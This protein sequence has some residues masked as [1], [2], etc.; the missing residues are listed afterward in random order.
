MGRPRAKERDGEQLVSGALRTYTACILCCP[1]W[2]Q[3]MVPQNNYNINV[4]DL[5]SQIAVTNTTTVKKFEMLWELA[6]CDTETWSTKCCFGKM[7]LIDLLDS[8]FP[9]TFNLF[10]KK[11]KTVSASAVNEVQWN[12]VY[13]YCVS[14]LVLP[15]KT[16]GWEGR[17]LAFIFSQ[18]CSPWS[19]RPGCQQ[20]WFLLGPF[21]LA[22]RPHRLPVSSHGPSSV[23]EPPQGLSVSIFSLFLRTLIRLD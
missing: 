16:P 20:I 10:K 6:K 4:K 1:M 8:G 7:V 17:T 3:F 22:C 21:S 9:Q 12:K 13:L 15:Y 19:P 18:F 23:C 11:K 5:W 14:V 2:V